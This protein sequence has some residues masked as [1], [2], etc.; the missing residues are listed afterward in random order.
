MSRRITCSLWMLALML[1]A[2]TVLATGFGALRLPVSLLLRD[3]DEALRQIWIPLRLPRVLLSLV[4]GASLA[5]AGCVMSGLFR[6]PL[7]DP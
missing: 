1:V 5:V 2:M 4:V 7:A 3:G 6:N